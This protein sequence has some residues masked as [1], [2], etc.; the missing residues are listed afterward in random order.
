[1]KAH[2]ALFERRERAKDKKIVEHFPE[3]SVLTSFR[4]E[5]SA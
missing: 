1:M 4:P 3:A 5:I 2:P